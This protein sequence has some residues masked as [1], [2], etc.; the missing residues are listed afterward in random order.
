MS[1]ISGRNTNISGNKKVCKETVAYVTNY[2]ADKRRDYYMQEE[3]RKT[4]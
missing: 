1:S 2:K 3:I 4:K